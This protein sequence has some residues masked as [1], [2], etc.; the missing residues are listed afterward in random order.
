MTDDVFRISVWEERFLKGNHHDDEWA[1]DLFRREKKIDGEPVLFRAATHLKTLEYLKDKHINLLQRAEDGSTLLIDTL[2]LFD[3]P[4]YRWLANEF[5]Q[6]NAIDFAEFEGITPLSSKIKFGELE[7]ARIL[8]E[9]GASIK[10]EAS[11]AR[12]G[13][14][15]LGIPRQA[16]LSS[17]FGKDPQLVAIE[18]LK[19]LVEFGYDPDTQEVENLL[20]KIREDKPI[21]RKWIED[22]L[23]HKKQ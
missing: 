4:S 16:V 21:L 5:K 8:L 15:K 12:Y 20:S 13:G 11:I 23:L 1:L 2:N 22:N 7:K 3:L 10:T 17:S 9:N 14:A 19:L 18:A 6:N